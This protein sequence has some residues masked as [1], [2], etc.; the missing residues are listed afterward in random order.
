MSR[1]NDDSVEQIKAAVD[2]VDLVS[3][4]TQLKRSGGR[5]VG[6]CP[7]HDERT[8]S[9]SVN[10]VDKLYYCFGCQAKGDAI[11]FVREKEGLDFTAAVEWLGRRYG[12]E[13][14]YEATSPAQ[15]RRIDER[16]RLT[17]LLEIATDFYQRYLWDA[18]EAGAARAYLAERGI[19]SDVAH[20]FRLGFAPSA[21][22]RVC[23]AARGRG[24]TDEELAAAGIS[25]AGRRGSID[26]FRGRLMFPLTDARGRVTGFGAR[27]MP[28]G[29]PP[30]YKNSPEG[31]LFHKS[32]ILYGLDRARAQ[33]AKL[34]SAIVVEGYTDVLALHQAGITNAVASMGTAL[35][36][37]QVSELRRLCDTVH[38]A[39]DA[40]AAGQEAS[41]RGMQLAVAKGLQV[42]VVTLPEGRDPADVVLADS[43]VF[44]RAIAEA[45]SFLTYR[46]MLALAEGGDRDRIF[47]RVREVLDAAAPSIERDE[48]VRVV[49]DRLRL[50]DDLTAL[51]SMRGP[52]AASPMLRRR[53]RLSPRERDERLFLGMCL[54]LPGEA[55]PLLAD[56]ATAHFS[57]ASHWEAASFIRRHVSGDTS[58]EEAQT[59]APSIAELTA[60]AEREGVS[61]AVLVELRLKL[62][63][64][65]TE[66]ELKGLRENADLSVSQEQH[67]QELQ[68]R[69]LSILESI[70]NSVV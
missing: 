14:Q 51:L 58:P 29:E 18:A 13:P 42:R 10:P 44:R 54:A 5:Y 1:I 37:H 22:D 52:I 34:G 4:Y 40:D 39:F 41:L 64:H 65:R 46:V 25:T 32:D 6:R 62:E 17:G 19:G 3:G 12:V 7:F 28:G 66:D 33:I 23:R 36:E 31:P 45:P 38:L 26:R 53:T 60:L 49:A 35:T 30:K 48:L 2:M 11:T 43:E 69:R 55:E 50:T 15:R 21:W 16:A 61:V 9:F 20:Q 59:W 70:R 24:F 47:Q 68:E 67:L 56:L 57:E 27:Q 63:L 8:G